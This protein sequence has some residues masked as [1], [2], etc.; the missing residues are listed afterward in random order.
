MEEP[1][2]ARQLELG[3]I[4]KF[5]IPEELLQTQEE[6]DREIVEFYHFVKEQ[7]DGFKNLNIHQAI[8]AIRIFMA[9]LDDELSMPMHMWEG[10]FDNHRDRSD[11]TGKF[12]DTVEF[13]DYELISTPL[14]KNGK[15][16][17][18]LLRKRGP[19]PVAT[20]SDENG[21]D[22][23]SALQSIQDMYEQFMIMLEA[24]ETMKEDNTYPLPQTV[25][26]EIQRMKSF[27]GKEVKKILDN[28]RVSDINKEI[29]KTV[30]ERN[31]DGLGVLVDH[32][33]QRV[34]DVLGVELTDKQIRT[35]FHLFLQKLEKSPTFNINLASTNYPWNKNQKGYY[36]R[37]KE[38][39]PL[40]AVPLSP[41][42]E[43]V[44]DDKKEILD[45]M[46]WYAELHTLQNSRTFIIAIRALRQALKKNA[47]VSNDYMLYRESKTYKNSPLTLRNYEEGMPRLKQTLIEKFG[48]CVLEKDGSHQA[49]L[50]NE[51]EFYNEFLEEMDGW[52]VDATVKHS[53]RW[54]VVNS[55]RHM[56]AAHDIKPVELAIRYI[57]GKTF[58]GD[59]VETSK[60][61]EYLR[62]QGHDMDFGTILRWYTK[63]QEINEEC[64]ELLGYN[65]VERGVHRYAFELNEEY[66]KAPADYVSG[67]NPYPVDIPFKDEGFDLGKF[68]ELTKRYRKLA[69]SLSKKEDSKYS[70]PYKIMYLLA[71]YSSRGLAISTSFLRKN[72]GGSDGPNIRACLYSLFRLFRNH[73]EW[74]IS[75]EK[76][77]KCTYYL[78]MEL[79]EEPSKKPS[80]ST[81]AFDEFCDMS[82]DPF[83]IEPDR[84]PL[85]DDTDAEVDLVSNIAQLSITDKTYYKIKVKLNSNGTVKFDDDGDP[86]VPSELKPYRG[87]VD[88][89]FQIVDKENSGPAYDVV[90]NRVGL[91]SEKDE[92]LVAIDG[93]LSRV[94]KIS[95]N[96][97]E[98]ISTLL[99]TPFDDKEFERWLNRD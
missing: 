2:F 56:G 28:G 60:L 22:P 84:A 76:Y 26:Q 78:K 48:I 65:L 31:K 42:F 70:T 54:R 77:D 83:E 12:R 15:W 64:P 53:L 29:A 59:V 68:S 62:K 27:V 92:I 40:R 82:F 45:R 85:P 43:E 11:N 4:T 37:K 86:I 44:P 34:R 9:N 98:P 19:D 55:L 16:K 74:G 17:G 6:K 33:A 94:T 24:G 41:P 18:Y 87:L 88:T 25:A 67:V 30:Y 97:I 20:E 39:K 38:R 47:S 52:K 90:A 75:L 46:L 32:I 81:K 35:K 79:L 1:S 10:I 61:Q 50:L 69:V 51:P 63:I 3:E 36:F 95:R 8:A 23:T 93:N 66:K 72:L 5:S 57:L 49:I 58:E 13:T 71:E 14:P 7:R 96:L 21:I 80:S 91:N 99:E 89:E 73:P